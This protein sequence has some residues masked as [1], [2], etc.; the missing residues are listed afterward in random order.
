MVY[1]L[2]QK[3]DLSNLAV[4]DFSCFLCEHVGK[5]FVIGDERGKSS[6]DGVYLHMQLVTRGHTYCIFFRLPKVFWSKNPAAADLGTEA[7]RV[8]LLWPHLRRQYSNRVVRSATG[9]SVLPYLPVRRDKTRRL[10]ASQP[11][12]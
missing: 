1:V 10:L 11:S 9:E 2:G 5:W 4:D 7:V 3:R 8:R 6:F 12:M